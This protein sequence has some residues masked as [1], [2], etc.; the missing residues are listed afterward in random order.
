MT[1]T[2]HPQRLA[3]LAGAFYLIIIAFALFAYL[4][5]RGTL[6]VPADVAMTATN[7]LA[8]QPLYRYGFGAAV[9]VV[10]SNPPMGFFLFE[11]L[12]AVNPRR[13][14]IAL[15]FITISTTLEA[16]NLVNYVAPFLTLTLPD[17]IG[18]D[19]SV[20][21]AI[22]TASLR[23]FGYGFDVSLVFFGVFCGLIGWLLLGA[24]FF[25][26]L[27]GVAMIVAGGTYAINSF[28]HFLA[29]P[30]PYIPWVTLVAESALAMW[31][32][33]VGVDERKWREQVAALKQS[34]SL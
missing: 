1:F 19:L 2:E 12:K 4:R 21:Y 30:I 6:I 8:H 31:L 32:T 26:K 27:L 25:P 3:R 14:G 10:L 9:I 18:A 17:H 24:R 7:L 22:A 15:I 13:A 5:V 20:R 23:L 16:V 34:H 29:L 33:L 28:Q 11:L